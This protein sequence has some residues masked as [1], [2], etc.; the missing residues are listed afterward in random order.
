MKKHCKPTKSNGQN[1]NDKVD[2]NGKSKKNSK[3]YKTH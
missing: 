3:L 2:K 1:S